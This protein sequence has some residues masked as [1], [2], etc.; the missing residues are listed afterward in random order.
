MAATQ[1]TLEPDIDPNSSD[2]ATVASASEPRTPPTI[3]S[4][5]STRR[6]A[7]PPRPMI[8]PAK[9]NSGTASSGKLSRPPNSATCTGAIEPMFMATM[10]MDAAAISATKIGTPRQS[11]TTGRPIR[12]RAAI[13]LRLAVGVFDVAAGPGDLDRD[14]EQRHHDD[15]KKRD[16]HHAL[17]YPHRHMQRIADLIEVEQQT[18][19]A[20]ARIRHRQQN[21]GQHERAHDLQDL[22]P[23]G[24]G[25]IQ[26]GVDPDM[27]LLPGDRHGSDIDPED[28]QVEHRLFRPRQR[29]LEEVAKDDVDGV[30]HDDRQ[31]RR[32]PGPETDIGDPR[33]KPEQ[34]S[35][36]LRTAIRLCIHDEFAQSQRPRVRRRKP[37]R[38]VVRQSL[39]GGTP[40]SVHRRG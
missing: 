8:S 38:Y 14:A 40:A 17:G 37:S 32:S 12:T 21:G 39:P 20:K 2:D 6:R 31:Q 9:M 27:S 19:D 10:P 35:P 13:S 4:A 16:R 3:D 25:E 18:D 28:H 24:R 22:A 1:P 33:S 29:H 5:H 36:E 26:D 34:G 15:Q 23:G 30:E 11:R 7:M